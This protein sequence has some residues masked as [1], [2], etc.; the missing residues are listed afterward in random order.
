MTP[1]LRELYQGVILDHYKK[2]RNFRRPEGS[3]LS[4]EGHNPLCGDRV[5]VYVTVDNGIIC[6]IGFQ[7]VGCAIC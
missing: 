6:D 3:G 2:P 1:D 5:V 4:A 7:G